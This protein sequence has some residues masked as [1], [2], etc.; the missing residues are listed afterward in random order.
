MTEPPLH[1]A[2]DRTGVVDPQ[3]GPLEQLLDDAVEAEI[4]L[5]HET[6]YG[7]A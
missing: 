2:P 6:S 1:D 7:E 3:A 4:E 5:R